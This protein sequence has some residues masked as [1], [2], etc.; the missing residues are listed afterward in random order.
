M[1]KAMANER[2]AELI[3]MVNRDVHTFTLRECVDQ[4]D[5]LRDQLRAEKDA[6]CDAC[7]EN[8]HEMKR[9]REENA[10][11]IAA[12]ELSKIAAKEITDELAKLR[13]VVDAAIKKAGMCGSSHPCCQALRDLDEA[14]P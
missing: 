7:A 5:R 13:K 10:K 11:Y 4:I 2:L 12:N 6:Q 14:K 9:L 1:S 8:H 3:K